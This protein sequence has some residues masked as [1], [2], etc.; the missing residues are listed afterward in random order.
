MSRDDDGTID[1]GHI[2]PQATPGPMGDGKAPY[3]A[4]DGSIDEIKRR[5][6]LSEYIGRYVA[7]KKQGRDMT[8]LCPFHGEKTPSFSVSPK[9]FYYCFGCHAKGDLYAFAMA[10]HGWGFGEAKRNLGAEAGV[11]VAKISPVQQKRI[12]EQ[13]A[14][15]KTN[16]IAH[17]FFEHALWSPAGQEAR[18]YLQSRGIPEKLARD[19]RLGYGGKS[20]DFFEYLKQKN[21]SPELATRAGFLNEDKT[22]CLFDSRLVFPIDNELRRTVGFGARRLDGEK[23]L[24]YI[25]TRDSQLFNKSRLLYG[26]GAAQEFIRVQKRVLVVEGYTDVMACVRAGLKDAVAALGTA[27]TDDHAKQI[28]RLAKSAVVLLDG[29]AAG[30]RASYGAAEKLIRAKL[31]TNVA[32][33]PPGEDPDSLLSKEGA[34]ALQAVVDQARPA[35]EYFIEVA[36][37]DSTMSI[38]DRVEAAAELAPVIDAYG[39]G[40]SRELYLDQLSQKVG[41]SVEKLQKHVAQV[42]EKKKNKAKKASRRT[43]SKP[44]EPSPQG[45][46]DAPLPPFGGPPTEAFEGEQIQ[47]KPVPTGFELK[48]LQ[49]LLLFPELRL[50]F[51]EVADFALTELFAELLEELAASEAPVADVVANYVPD[52]RWIKRL[53]EVQAAGETEEGEREVK[54]EQTFRDVLKQLKVRHLGQAI[55][56]VSQSIEEIELRGQE[57][58]EDLIRRLQDLLRR[59]RHLL[60]DLEK[61]PSNSEGPRADKE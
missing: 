43:A 36:F 57:P 60:S 45:F 49:E 14:L 9:G 42:L 35:A 39:E 32:A 40:L 13:D 50:R 5:I 55:N 18:A 25:N 19:Y 12:Q 30:I 52:V 48:A 3:K 54:A 24:K 28:A 2:E 11:E 59:K 27:F 33:L 4:D 37:S 31:K 17:A 23:H 16:E 61:G 34:D 22:R 51:E 15:I 21:V 29:D 6:D 46:Q 47:Q 7:L 1:S 44:Q 41:V 58:S 56:G 38:E 26:W 8:G 20:H 53:G 10:Y